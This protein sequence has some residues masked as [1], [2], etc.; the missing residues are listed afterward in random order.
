MWLAH[1][2]YFHQE[3]VS[4]IPE[5]SCNEPST[6]NR[7]LNLQANPPSEFLGSQ[8]AGFVS[9]T[10]EYDLS[11]LLIQG[12]IPA[13][14]KG[15]LL[16]TGPAQFEIGSSTM[17]YWFDGFAMLHR[18]TIEEGKVAYKN[19]FLQSTYYQTCIKHGRVPQG[20][21]EGA[22]KSWFSRIAS[23][24]ATPETY[25]NGNMN[26]YAVG[27]HIMSATE[28][29]TPRRI[30]PHTL[31]TLELFSYN[32]MFESHLTTAQPRYDAT[33]N[34]MLNFSVQF[35]TSSFYHV[36]TLNQATG[37]HTII[38][39]LPVER[40]AYMRT[41]SITQHYC[42]LTEIPFT[43]NPMDLLFAAGSF[44]ESYKWQP[45]M[46]TKIILIDRTSGKIVGTYTTEPFFMFNHVNAF[47]EQDERSMLDVITYQNPE[48]IKSTL[49]SHLRNSKPQTY[50][51]SELKRYRIT[52]TTKSVSSQLLSKKSVEFPAINQAYALKPYRYMYALGSEHQT[53]FAH[54]LVKIDIQTGEY[55]VWQEDGCYAGQPTFVAAP[56]AQRE[57]DGILFS[58][59]L[60]SKKT[61]FVFV[62]IRCTTDERGRRVLL[63]HHIPLGTKGTFFPNSY[64]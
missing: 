61:N 52:P 45:K 33:T 44:I 27:N 57:D 21:A 13:W 28:S 18:F 30:D 59:V 46:G 25:D 19:R 38:A 1:Q 53:Q 63:P 26:I 35:G 10:E 9:L 50:P 6:T 41:L 12:T 55:L 47:E 40:P 14:L 51:L 62:T 16:V 43:V 42:I 5:A 20:F 58:I 23:A 49:L 39:S 32:D 24:F 36:Y 34:E 37:Q 64:N 17:K 29:T 31:Q 8:A 56:E 54:Q 15:N 22:K 7:S 4:I 3:M 11:D 2:T 60:D 48:V